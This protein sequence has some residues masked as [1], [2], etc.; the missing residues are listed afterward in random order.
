MIK[1]AKTFLLLILLLGSQLFTDGKLLASHYMGGEITWECLS[2]G[3]FRFIMK[4]YRECNGITYSTGEIMHIQ[5]YPGLTQITMALKPGANPHDGDDGILDGKTDISPHCWN[6]ASQIKCLPTPSTANTGAIE[7]WYFTSDVAYPAGVLL[8]GV[9]PASG[10][11]FYNDGCC[12]NPSV[13][14]V[15]PTSEDWFLRAIMY[16]YNGQNTNPCYDNSPVF[17]EV[18]STVICTGY[19]F[20]YNHNA[21]DKELDSLAFSWA[22]ALQNATTNMGY[23]ATYTY[24][25]PLPGTAQNPL[26]VPATMNPYNG[27]ISYTSYTSGAFV[28]VTKVTAYRC[29]IKIAEIFR[30]MQIVL[31]ACPGSNSPPTVAGPFYNPVSGIYEFTDTVYA[32][33]TVDVDITGIDYGVLPNGNPQTVSLEASGQ[34]FGA[35]FV[36]EASGCPRPP[37]AT[38]TPPPTLSAM[39]AVSTHFH[40]RT[41]CDHLTHPASITGIPGVCGTMFNVHNFVIKVYD[42][43]C[44]APGIKIATISIVVLPVP[45]LPPPEVKCTRV[46]INGDITLNWIPPID[47]MNSFN[48]FYVYHSSSPTGPFVKIDSIFDIN[49][50]TKTYSGLGGNTGQQYFYMITRSGCYGLYMSHPSDTVSTIYLNVAAIGGGPI[51]QLNWNPVHNPLFSSSSQ[52][53][54]IYRE[55]PAG[56]W[57]FLDSTNQL[58]YLDTVTICSAFINYRV[59]IADSFGCVSVSSIDGEQLHDGFPPDPTILDS[60]SVDISTAK[61]ILGW[62]SNTSPDAVKYYIYRKDIGTGAWFI[63]DSV[64]V[65]ATS[66]MDMTSTPQNNSE[67]YCIA[68][69]DSCKKLSP[70]SPEHETIFLSPPIINAC[71]DKI[72]LHWTSYINFANPG[73]QGYRL[74]VSENGGPYTLLADLP[75]TGLSYEHTGLVNGS[76]YCY[77]VRAYDSLNQKTSTSNSQC[78]VVTKPNQPRFIY[79]RYATVQNND[80]IR[81]GFYVDSTA[82]ITKFKIL[83]SVDGINYD[84]I[85]QFPP[86][87]PYSNVTY[88][89]NSVNVSEKSYYYKVVVSDSC[90]LD[91]LTSNVGRS[92]Y[93][94]GT[95]PEY[96]LNNL[97]WNH[98]EDRMPVAYNLW[99]EVDQYEPYIKVISLVMNESSYTDNVEFY[100]E[101]GGR[102]KYMIEAELYDVYD[103]AYVFED[104]V[105]SNEIVLLQPPRLY[106]PNAFAPNGLNNLFKPVGVYTEKDG[107]QMIIYDRWGRKVFETT[108]YETGWD[109]TFEGK[110]CAL[111]VY[112]YY[113]KITNAYNKIFIKRGIVTLVR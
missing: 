71:A 112:T 55:F 103:S 28:T 57:N 29:G 26:N 25:S 108:D 40:W 37:C 59:E 31:L 4:L 56:S 46:D 61:A 67:T 88:D 66:Y 6:Y 34:D 74:L 83:R 76:N 51:A 42:D 80:F 49:Q 19:P 110:K 69:V 2:N 16:P 65:P 86:S 48:G 75:A 60:V 36:S 87:S 64:D 23:T 79:L 62:H 13:N 107:Y 9:P 15:N 18:P 32:G 10:W 43:F 21:T 77:L 20:K 84:T 27:E 98:Y 85:G 70:M 44:P 89:D 22:P 92:I 24:N 7:E 99:R 63:R 81:L 5:G 39:L 35:G 104:K 45:V 50:T 41:T 90:S 101:S 91:M 100:T 95:V 82:Y 105:L 30:E 54:H 113:V 102:F 11:I 3:R 8:S 53:Y 12:R 72:T 109:G 97:Y 73:L 96:L 1:P 106:V 93:L 52:Y 33:D 17:A 78:V 47:T 94:E 68:A 111:G 58:T 14:M 38:L